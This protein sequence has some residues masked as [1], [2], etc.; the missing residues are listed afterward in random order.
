GEPLQLLARGLAD[1]SPIPLTDYLSDT[2]YC[3][4]S[5]AIDPAGNRAAFDSTRLVCFRTPARNPN[6]LTLQLAFNQCEGDTL[7]NALDGTLAGQRSGGE[8]AP[9]YTGQ[10]LALNGQTD[11][12]NLG[13]APELT[14]AGEATLAVWVQ[15]EKR[16]KQWVIGRNRQGNALSWILRLEDDGVPA[17]FL[18]GN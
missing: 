4:T 15:T 2:T 3:F 16:A 17:L 13:L 12:V 9:G 1:G 18:V 7:T 11:Y 5:Q 10:G 8:W 6:Q 14:F